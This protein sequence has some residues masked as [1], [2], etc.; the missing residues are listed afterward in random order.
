MKLLV[1]G[2]AGFVGST[3]VDALVGQGHDVVVLDDFDDYYAPQIK[4]VNLASALRS[5]RVTRPITTPAT[6]ATS[7][8]TSR[9]P[10]SSKSRARTS[11]LT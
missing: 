9:G 5:G 7:P 8:R 4:R 6:R 1:T 11:W 2:G 3:L 10:S